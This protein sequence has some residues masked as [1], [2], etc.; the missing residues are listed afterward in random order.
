MNHRSQ[1][2]KLQTCNIFVPLQSFPELSPPMLLKLVV[3]VVQLVFVGLPEL[4]VMLLEL[5]I[6]LLVCFLELG[7][8]K[9][10]EIYLHN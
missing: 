2:P 1:E 4:A 7:W 10:K 8:A 5:L 3:P 9:F 6:P